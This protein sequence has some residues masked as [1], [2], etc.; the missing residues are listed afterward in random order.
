MLSTVSVHVIV[1]VIHFIQLSS[2]LVNQYDEF[3]KVS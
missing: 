3:G 1:F 2:I